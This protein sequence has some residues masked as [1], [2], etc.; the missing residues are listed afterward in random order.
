M[1]SVLSFPKSSKDIVVSILSSRFP[2]SLKEIHLVAR[3]EYGSS[4]SYQAFH[5]LVSALVVEGVVLKAEG[6]FALNP[7][8]IS[9]MKLFSD[10]LGLV[11]TRKS[12]SDFGSSH[13]FNLRFAGFIP[14]ARFLIHSFWSNFPNPHNEPR[15]LLA[16][17]VWLPAGADEND[18]AALKQI[19]GPPFFYGLYRGSSPLDKY[20]ASLLVN[21][22][23]KALHG[24]ETGLDGDLTVQGD[25]VAQI[26]YP[27]SFK[28]KLD[29]LFN[30]TKSVENFDLMKAFELYSL[31]D[32][33]KVVITFN[34]MV[35]AELRAEAKRLYEKAT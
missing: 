1:S 25:H 19:F 26:F 16:H 15:V 11:Y 17:H 22:G 4:V 9:K 7:L 28:Q 12:L 33:I 32:E 31:P 2:L 24:I 10:Q 5:K 8:W 20:A 6:G 35:A 14:M 23:K 34:P 21:I 3:R 30:S 27:L 13:V 29:E 18:F